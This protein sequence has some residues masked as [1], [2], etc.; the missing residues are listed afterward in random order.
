MAVR[1]DEIDDVGVR[2]DEIPDTPLTETLN[3]ADAVYDYAQAERQSLE[4]S[5]KQVR[6]NTKDELYRRNLN[7]VKKAFPELGEY[8][9]NK[10]ASFGNLTPPDY[11]FG[12]GTPGEFTPGEKI[13]ETAKRGQTALTGLGKLPGIALKALGESAYTNDEIRAMEQSQWAL[14]RKHA[15]LLKTPIGKKGRQ[16]FDMI[17]RAG[18]AYVDFVGKF[19]MEPSVEAKIALEQPFMANPI[20]RTAGAVAESGPSYGLA[21]VSSLTTGNPNV[22]LYILGTTTASSAYEKY[23][24]ELV[25]PDLALVAALAEGS[26]EILT[27]KVP[28]DELMKGAGRPLMSRFIRQGTM[29]SGQELLAQL[30]QNY[31]EAV[32]K[33]VDPENL[34]TIRQAAI[35]EWRTISKGWEDA[36]AAGFIMGGG[37]GAISGEGTTGTPYQSEAR[38]RGLYSQRPLQIQRELDFQKQAEK[39]KAKVKAEQSTEA[40]RGTEAPAAEPEPE[41]VKETETLTDKETQDVQGET[42]EAPQAEAVLGEEGEVERPPQIEAKEDE[43]AKERKKITGLL[44]NN[45]TEVEIDELERLEQLLKNKILDQ[46]NV[47]LDPETFVIASK[48]G[49]FYIKAGFRGFKAWSEQVKQRIGEISNYTLRTIYANLRNEHEGLDADE[50]IDQTLLD[51][52]GEGET[53][54]RGLSQSTLS[55]AITNELVRENEEILGDLPTYQKMNMADQSDKALRLIEQDL[56]RAR[57][58][59]LYEES[60]PEGLYPENVFTALRVWAVSQGDA[61]L[62]LDLA[63]SEQSARIATV[64]GKRIKS[65]DTG[66]NLGDPISAIREVVEARKEQLARKGKDVS[67]L[68]AELRD[69]QIKFERAQRQLDAYMK[70]KEPVSRRNYGSQNKLVTRTEYDEITARWKKKNLSDL[71]KEEGGYAPNA[72]DFSDMLKVGMFHLEALGRDFAKWSWQ[73]THDFGEWVTPHLQDTYDK[74]LKEAEDQGVHIIES[75]RLIAKKKRMS[76]L[77]EKAEGQLEALDLEKMPRFPIELDE[78]GK[79][80]QQEYDLARAKLKT[81]QKV[82]NI[83]TEEEVRIIT[84][85]GKDIQD[86]RQAMEAGERRG[87]GEPATDNEIAYGV[88]VALFVDYVNDLKAEANKKTVGELIKSYIQNPSDFLSDFAGTLKSA[89]ASLD[90]SFHLRQ[91]LPTFLKG[92]TGDIPSAKIWLKTFMKSWKIMWDTLKGRKAM[93]AVFAEIISDPEYDLLKRSKVA[94]FSIEEEIPVDIPSRI[95]LFGIL[96]RMGEN[97]F[98]GSAHYM[99]YQ[100]AKQYL[101]IWRKSGIELNKKQLESIGRLANSQTGRGE[102]ASRGRTPGLLNNVFWSPRNLRAYVDIL[103]L[104]LFDKNISAFARYQAAK[105]LLRYISGAAMILSLANWLDD[106]SVTDDPRSADF[107]KIRIGNTRFAVGGGITPLIVLASRLST[108]KFTSSTTGETKSIDSGKFGAMTGKDLIFNFLENKAS[109]A[110]QLVL[111]LIEQK[112]WDGDELS[113]PQLASDALTPLIIQNILENDQVNDSA[114]LLAVLIAEGLGVNVQSYEPKQSKSKGGIK[115]YGR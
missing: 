106:D 65:L 14:R 30:G 23:R 100:L 109:P 53:A 17:R 28:M 89:K 94:I 78:E 64:L 8:Q 105:N 73:M 16:V 110:S 7:E 103:T 99:R 68:E 97:A 31:V 11:D 51:E 6:Q 54:V 79:R 40:E 66:E 115:T 52:I 58:I 9:F 5:S 46:L 22:G 36:M 82:A 59:A 21:V 104:H 15:Q 75:K 13:F 93:H 4:D 102:T 111:S 87:D 1:F 35:Q 112:T 72:Q 81:A 34:S 85:L 2:I 70:Y 74:A 80:L 56:A 61:Q 50:L 84:Q 47:G 55:Q 24:D 44:S 96:F 71:L 76:T 98:T 38:M 39:I 77:K 48:I 113:I 90:N 43:T 107:G 25:D 32:T 20:Y 91:G 41:T 88:S 60:A 45:L 19:N 29:E 67:Q 26:I 92:L 114:N 3:R 49:G 95:P 101:N 62:M 42:E 83:I 37:A 57:R 69:L 86:K 12:I 27:E 33:E 108:R 63:T 10:N 18:N